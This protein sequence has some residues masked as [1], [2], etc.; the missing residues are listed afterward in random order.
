MP[1]SLIGD[2]Y[3]MIGRSSEF[4]TLPS[5]WTIPSPTNNFDVVLPESMVV[6]NNKNGRNSTMITSECSIAQRQTACKIALR[7]VAIKLKLSLTYK[8]RRGRMDIG[9]L[10]VMGEFSTMV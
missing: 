8:S 2:R 4:P 6:N 1:T 3:D 9:Q 10:K 7:W 5:A